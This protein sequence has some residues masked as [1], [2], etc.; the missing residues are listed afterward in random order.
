MHKEKCIGQI[1]SAPSPKLERLHNIQT[2]DLVRTT[3]LF[4]RFETGKGTN[5]FN[6]IDYWN[7]KSKTRTFL[8]LVENNH[9]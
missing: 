6:S 1:K 3:E 8:F 9:D 5:K 4:L 7:N 2:R